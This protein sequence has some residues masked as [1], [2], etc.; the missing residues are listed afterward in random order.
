MAAFA[1]LLSL[2]V[3]GSA[4]SFSESAAA[5]RSAVTELLT[6]ARCVELPGTGEIDCLR[7]VDVAK[8]FE[9]FGTIESFGW[10]GVVGIV[11]CFELSGWFGVLGCSESFGTTGFLGCSGI[12]GMTG[13]WRFSTYITGV[14]LPGLV[15]TT[16]S[17]GRLSFGCQLSMLGTVGFKTFVGSP[18]SVVYVGVSAPGIGWLFL[19]TGT[20]LPTF[21]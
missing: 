9:S 13:F 7:G 3:C 8:C 14:S 20:S 16:E 11:G 5:D 4:V 6:V 21:L 1:W 15:G 2:P 19:L 18:E 17:P 12:N 10:S